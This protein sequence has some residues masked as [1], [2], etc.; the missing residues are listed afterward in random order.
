M[1]R[2]EYVPRALNRALLVYVSLN[3]TAI[4][5]EVFGAGYIAYFMLYYS[6]MLLG[7]PVLLAGTFLIWRKGYTPARYLF[8]ARCFSEIGMVLN[9]LLLGN[10]IRVNIPLWAGFLAA[11]L[12]DFAPI[13]ELFLFS[14]ALAARFTTLQEEKQ[15]AERK[16][17]E[18]ELYRLENEVLHNA[19][20]EIMNQQREILEQSQQIQSK[21]DEIILLNTSLQENNAQLVEISKEKDELMGIVSHDLKNPIGAVRGYAELIENQTFKGDEV[22]PISSQIVQISNRMLELV[23]NLLDLNH[24]E[25]GILQLNMVSFDISP[26]V[27]AVVEQYHAPAEAKQITLHYNQESSENIAFAEEQALMQVLDNLISNA[28]KYSPLG[29]RILVRVVNTDRAVRI[30]IQDE[31]PGLSEDDKSKLFGKFARLSARPTGGEYSTGLGLSI[32]KKMV[33]AMNGKVWCESELGKGATFIV[34]LP[35][36]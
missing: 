22:V 17:L 5:L 16:A 7:A 28:V 18:G 23:K 10:L 32:V 19:H 27:Q 21:N 8:I 20:E 1:E 26:I 4:V 35:C 12:Q 24:L 2:R 14:F 15:V 3:I 31:G 30:E 9:I 6:F 36:V 34:E 33:E 25:S 11:R 13:L 29:K